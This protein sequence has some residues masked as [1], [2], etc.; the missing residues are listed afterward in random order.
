MRVNLRQERI[1]FAGYTNQVRLRGLT[2]KLEFCNP[3]RRVRVCVATVTIREAAT[4]L[5]PPFL[6]L[7]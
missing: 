5:Q 6:S 3:R 4:R 1:E 7:S 2:E